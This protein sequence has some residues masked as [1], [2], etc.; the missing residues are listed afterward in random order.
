M[1]TCTE[2]WLLEGNLGLLSLS[3]AAA[4]ED[5]VALAGS[6]DGGSEKGRG[7]HVLC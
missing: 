1:G 4:E 5:M 2:L 3:M 6:E 7:E